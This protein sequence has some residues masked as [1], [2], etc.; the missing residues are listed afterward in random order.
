MV[1]VVITTYKREPFM[2]SRAIESVIRQTYQDL[3][4]IIVDD[5]PA[6]FPLRKKVEA[7]VYEFRNNNKGIDV[8]Y[9]AHENNLGACAARNTGIIIAKGEFILD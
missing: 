3:E 4:I 9:I 8:Q 7:A 2:V 5:S 1:S 6:I